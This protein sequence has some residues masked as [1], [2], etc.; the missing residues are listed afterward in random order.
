MLPQS[1]IL[2]SQEKFSCCRRRRQY[3]T[4]ITGHAPVDSLAHQAV[5]LPEIPQSPP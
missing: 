3:I 1:I 5:S 2:N 4:N